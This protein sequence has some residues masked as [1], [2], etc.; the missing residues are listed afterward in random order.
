MEIQELTLTDQAENL[1][2]DLLVLHLVEV[3]V[4]VEVL[5]FL[6]FLRLPIIKLKYQQYLLTI[7]VVD[8]LISQLITDIKVKLWEQD[9]E[10]LGVL[11][12]PDSL[13]LEIKR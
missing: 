12:L 8:L 6:L 10:I 9:L 11:L 13:Q 4:E 5:L 7:E 3:E 1:T 2:E